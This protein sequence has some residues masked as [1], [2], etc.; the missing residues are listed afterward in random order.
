MEIIQGDNLNALRKLSGESKKFDLVELDGPYMAGLEGWDNLTEAEYIEH[1]ATRLTLARDILQPWGVVFLFG[2]PEG[3]AEVKAWAHKNRIFRL[4]RWIHWYKQRSA[5]R[6][7]KVE[8]ICLFIHFNEAGLLGD[9]KT[10]LRKEREERGLTISEAMA[11]TKCRGHLAGKGAGMMWFEAPSSHAPTG[12][13]YAELKNLF[14]LPTKYDKLPTLGRYQGVTDLDFINRSYPEETESLN[15]NGLRSKPVQL[16]LDLFAPTIPPTD[17]Y[18]A[19]ILYG[20]SG[21]AGIAAA[22][23]GYD[24]TVCEIDAGRCDAI[25]KRWDREVAKWEQYASSTQL[26]LPEPQQ[27]EMDL[28]C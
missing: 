2:Y 13:E 6:G 27:Q 25:G 17:N 14:Q 21:N 23:L 18:R 9:F 24:V 22:A 11:L 8:I 4:G 19:L 20:G 15:D 12:P 16:Y 10:F 3:C 7:R 5:H 28:T 1:Y 26:S